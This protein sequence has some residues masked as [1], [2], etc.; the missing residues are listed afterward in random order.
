MRPD[1]SLPPSYFEAMFQGD[2]DPWGLESRAYEA[3]KFDATVAALAGRTYVRAFEVGCAGGPLTRRLA[4]LCSSLLAIDVS[5]TA[6]ERARR[7]CAGLAQVR[8][9]QMAFPQTAPD[10]VDVDLIV[11]SEVAYY[12]DDADLE[13]AGAWMTE[14]LVP[15]GDILL[16]HWTGETDYPQTGDGA[17]EALR[18]GLG[19]RVEAI[20][21]RRET[22]Y[23]LDLWRGRDR[24]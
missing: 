4:P 2:P 12:W 23:R 19:D 14:A 5:E 8:F 24:G 9:D 11:L 1:R 22:A 15:G 17:V 7:K 21:S 13:R 3:E 6:L 10:F 18:S 16:V 20:V